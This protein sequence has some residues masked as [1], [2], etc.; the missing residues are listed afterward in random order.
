MEDDSMRFDED[1]TVVNLAQELEFDELDG[2][3]T[4][5]EMELLFARVK[6]ARYAG[7]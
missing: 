4:S 5:V 3:D 1:A 6:A 2:G 7:A